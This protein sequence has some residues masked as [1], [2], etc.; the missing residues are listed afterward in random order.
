MFNVVFFIYIL[1]S[2]VSGELKSTDL[3][4]RFP[5]GTEHA[6]LQHIYKLVFFLLQINVFRS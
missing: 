3:L 6:E 5:S 2:I 4:P 1:I